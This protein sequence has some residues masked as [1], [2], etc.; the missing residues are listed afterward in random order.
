MNEMKKN[1]EGNNDRCWF[2]IVLILCIIALFL[3]CIDAPKSINSY[4]AW[5]EFIGG[6]FGTIIAGIACFY[7]YKTYISQKEELEKTIGTAKTQQ[8]ETTFFN[9][10]RIH[11]ECLDAIQYNCPCIKQSVIDNDTDGTDAM[12]WWSVYESDKLEIEDYKRIFTKKLL[13]GELAMCSEFNML[14]RPKEE[15]KYFE[16]YFYSS[17]FNCICQIIK[18]LKEHNSDKFYVEFFYSQ[19]TRPEWWVLYDIF[20][21]GK[22]YISDNEVFDDFADLVEIELVKEK[23]M[24]V[25][26]FFYLSQKY[27]VTRDN[28]YKKSV[29]HE[30]L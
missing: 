28:M 23:K 29:K 8:F 30:Y 3:Y 27:N 20:L 25:Y 5:G 13:H 12:G 4:S 9:L 16:K 6:I 22:K 2:V 19:I 17:W 14:R 26:G 18:Y 11:K 1:K 10:I 7:V 15:L 21:N 24:F